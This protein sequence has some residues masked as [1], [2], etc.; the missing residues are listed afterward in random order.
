M[1]K[2]ILLILLLAAPAQA[3]LLSNIIPAPGGAT[4]AE[5][6]SITDTGENTEETDVEGA[7]AEIYGLIDAI[8]PQAVAN[9]DAAS[10]DNAGLL[11]YRV[12][13]NNSYLEMSM[14]TGVDA[15]TWVTIKEN[16]W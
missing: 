4:D 8:V 15:Y 2:L 3:E 7:L 13:G 5:D 9:E 16:N 14:Q 10:V 11:R 6:V 1:K 12:S